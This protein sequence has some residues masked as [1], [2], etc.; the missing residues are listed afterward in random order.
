MRR[1]EQERVFAQMGGPKSGIVPSNSQMIE[2]MWNIIREGIPKAFGAISKNQYMTSMQVDELQLL[3][4]VMIKQNY[5]LSKMLEQ[6]VESKGIS[7]TPMPSMEDFVK[8]VVKERDE[9]QKKREEELKTQQVN[10]EKDPSSEE[11]VSKLIIDPS[12][13]GKLND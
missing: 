13:K 1:N 6:V 7:L 2:S 10:Q 11:P 5:H 9:L 8:E 4:M 3:T 12:Q